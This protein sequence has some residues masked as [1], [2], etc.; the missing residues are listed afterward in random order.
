VGARGALR[1]GIVAA[2]GA[3]SAALPAGAS[4][5]RPKPCN[6]KGA[7]VVARSGT[8]LLLTAS[9][10]SDDEYG[11]GTRVMTC[12]KGHPRVTLVS[13]GPGDSIT[14][15]HAFFTPG[16]VAFAFS[17]ASTAC[18]KY[19]G[20]DPQCFSVGVTSYNRRTGK[21]RASGTGAAD[22]LVATSAGWMAWVS[23]PD[24]TGARALSAVAGAGQRVLAAGA[25]DPASLAVAGAEVRWSVGGVAAS[26]TLS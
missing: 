11:P 18:S 4:A 14:V 9:V 24:A 13:T 2:A 15:S 19:L 12:R 6:A 17:T 1:I 5:A 10:G 7:Q 25:I 8:A 21:L 3:L 16:Y 23:P 22:A 26:A 20:D